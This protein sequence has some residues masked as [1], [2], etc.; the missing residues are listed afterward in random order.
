MTCIWNKIF[1]NNINQFKS[2]FPNLYEILKNDIEN[3]KSLLENSAENSESKDAQENL[4]IL[5][6]IFSFWE[7][8]NAKS[9][10]VTVKENGIFLHSAYNPEREAQNLFDGIKSKN[11]QEISE[12]SDDENTFIFA[13][14]G[15]GYAPI[16]F[17][18]RAKDDLFIIIEPDPGFLFASMC[19]LDWTPIFNLEKC[20][21]ITQTMPDKIFPLLEKLCSLKKAKVIT[22]NSLTKHQEAWFKSFFTLLE[23]NKV[24][25]EININTLERFSSLWLKNSAKNISYFKTCPGISIYENMLD[26]KIPSLVVAAGPSLEKTIPYLKELEKRMVIICVDTAVKALLKNDIHPDFVLLVDP[27]YN[28][29]T[30]ILGQDLSSSCLVTESSVYP[31]VMHL[32]TRKKVFIES[33]FPLGRYFETNLLS[34]KSFG[35]ITA[36]GS[37]ATSCWEFAKYIGS[38]KIYV[39]GLDL[40]YPEKKTHIRGSTFEEK[41]HAKSTRVKPAENNLCSIL[42]N[43]T[44]EKALNFKNSEIITDSKMKLFAWWFESQIAKENEK[45]KNGSDFA[46]TFTLCEDG[47]KIPGMQVITCDELILLPEKLDEKIQFIKKAENTA[48]DFNEADFDRIYE[49]LCSLLDELLSEAKK[50]LDICK[51]ILKEPAAIAEQKAA[52]QFETLNKI[53]SY[54]MTS[55][56]KTVASLVFPSERQLEKLLSE[57]P[58]Q[59]SKVLLNITRS[60]VIYASLIDSIRK[61]QKYL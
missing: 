41:S 38:E 37:V 7:F 48:P 31:A 14:T 5:N 12:A 53:D 51:K 34:Q 57:E 58:V 61:Y 8:C 28:A 25:D 2:R 32:K 40:G 45:K 46:E 4:K 16:E 18:R 1:S 24:K 6:S 30:H 33:L 59:K 10:A 36:G 60:K 42:F 39:T 49:N 9:G 52:A 11:S 17:A 22:Q 3:I 29:A 50:G 19:T 35:K 26:K 21:I 20:V 44:N 27:Q 43:A 15:L 23:R 54:I 47:L 13:G 55:S 56:A